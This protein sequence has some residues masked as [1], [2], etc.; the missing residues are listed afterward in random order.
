[1]SRGK[2]NANRIYKY[3]NEIKL[4]EVNHI[5]YDMTGKEYS[6]CTELPFEKGYF[7]CF[8]LDNELKET[9]NYL[10]KVGLDYLIEEAE[11]LYSCNQP[12][13][14]DERKV[15]KTLDKL[16]KSLNQTIKQ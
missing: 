10:E 2:F 15:V 14:Y 12:I 9:V 8:D 11:L 3:M 1:M 6:I 7:E 4:I 13:I 16:I 5:Y